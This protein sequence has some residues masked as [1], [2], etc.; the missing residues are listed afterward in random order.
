MEKKP[1]YICQIN[2]EIGN[3]RA[4]SVHCNFAEGAQPREM[5]A[6]MDKVFDALDHQRLKRL[7]IPAVKGKIDEQRERL[8]LERE[9]IQKLTLKA[10]AGKLSTPERAQ[11]DAASNNIQHFERLIPEG[12]QFLAELEAKAA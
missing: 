8:R 10:Q 2:Y 11:F 5:S 3:G 7:E 9:N 6:E 4:V 1:G 12:E